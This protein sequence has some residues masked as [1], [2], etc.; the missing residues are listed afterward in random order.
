MQ[1]GHSSRRRVYH[2]HSMLLAALRRGLLPLTWL[3]A[4]SI[5]AA[6]FAAS[7]APAGSIGYGFAATIYAAASLLCH[8]RPERSF[9]LWA[10]QLPVCARCAGVYLGA[11]CATLVRTRRIRRPVAFVL[12]ASAPAAMTLVY[13]WSTGA[14]PA[15]WIRALTGLA[16]GGSVMLLLAGELRTSEVN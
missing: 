1:R 8:Q 6:A 9:H 5:P 10:V 13:E 11:A 7:R 15:N 12:A 16:I 14:M 4:A 3:W 2:H